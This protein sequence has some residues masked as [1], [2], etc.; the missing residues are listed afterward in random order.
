M[1]YEVYVDIL[2]LENF[3]MNTMLLFLTAWADHAQVK[4]MR[5]VTASVSGSLGACVLTMLSSG[6]SGPGYALGN[7]GLALGMVKIAFPGFRHLGFRTVN[8]YLQC[9][10]MS[11]ILRYLGQLHRLGGVW[12]AG[13]SSISF[14]FLA[15]ME[16]GQK[17]RKAD[18][19]QVYMVTLYLDGRQI[20]LEGLYD[21]GNSLCDPVSGKPVS[22]LKG[23]Y[24]ERLLLAAHSE[25]H[26]SYIPYHTISGTGILEKYVLDR[27]CIDKDGKQICIEHPEIARAPAEFTA[28]PLILHRDMLSS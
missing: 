15:A 21:T 11:G 6:L 14:L 2:F 3:W 17:K 4:K 8:L 16:Y 5:L 28:Y 10:V 18:R 12:F 20:T 26:P 23:Q 7:A 19:M 22:V 27:M 13:I 24:L 1:Y 9:F 25:P